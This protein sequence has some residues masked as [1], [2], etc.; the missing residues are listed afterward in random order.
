VVFDLLF[1]V[2]F[3]FGYAQVRCE[4]NLRVRE[5]CRAPL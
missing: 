2:R 5:K 3:L 1:F 4:P